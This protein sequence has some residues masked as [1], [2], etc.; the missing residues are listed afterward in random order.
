MVWE[1]YYMYNIIFNWVWVLLKCR[2]YVDMNYGWYFDN[3]IDNFVKLMD[4]EIIDG[5]F[6]ISKIG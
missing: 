1:L 2:I 5:I 3:K 4:K 6:L